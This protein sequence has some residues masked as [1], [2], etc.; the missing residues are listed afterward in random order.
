M[1]HQE[2]S[3]LTKQEKRQLPHHYDKPINFEGRS[4][5]RIEFWQAYYK[6]KDHVAVHDLPYTIHLLLKFGFYFYQC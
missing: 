1:P 3:G 5:L 6:L 4:R 2:F